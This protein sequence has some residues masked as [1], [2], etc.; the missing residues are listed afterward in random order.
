MPLSK[1]TD[2]ELAEIRETFSHFDKDGN[3]VIDVVEFTSL[4]DALDADLTEEQVQAG[5]ETLDEN[6]NGVIDYDEF[7]AWWADQ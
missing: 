5:L 4:L 2:E 7:L 1:L 3:G 6:H